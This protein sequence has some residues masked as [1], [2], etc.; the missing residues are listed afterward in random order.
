[1]TTSTPPF[2]PLRQELERMRFERALAK[3]EDLAGRRMLLT[4]IELERMNIMILGE[5]QDYQPWRDTPHTVALK[6]GRQATFSILRE[7]KQLVRDVLHAA[8]E[9]A[10]MG[11]PLEAAMHV[12]LEM[13]KLHAFNDANRRTAVLSAHYFFERYGLPINGRVLHDL[14]LGDLSQTDVQESLR[15]TLQQILR[16]ATPKA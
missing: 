2:N 8:T 3:V 6:S 16:F 13:V 5:S 11:N 14:G 7:P 15:A 1:M 4:T 12:Y 9:T 10:E